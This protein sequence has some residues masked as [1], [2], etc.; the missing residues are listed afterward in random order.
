MSYSH[1]VLTLEGLT[2][3]T[4]APT[5]SLQLSTWSLEASTSSEPCLT[6]E[7]NYVTHKLVI[8]T[9][10]LGSLEYLHAL[11]LAHVLVPDLSI[12]TKTDSATSLLTFLTARKAKMVAADLDLSC[13]PCLRLTL[14][15]DSIFV[16][17]RK[18]LDI[19]ESL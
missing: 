18:H 15:C 13:G 10:E 16:Q 5:L 11:A 17:Y 3:D 7:D 2:F 14:H 19:L 1:S 6:V 9:F 4:T 12:T 8:G